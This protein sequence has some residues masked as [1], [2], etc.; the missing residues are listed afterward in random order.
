MHRDP[1][2]FDD[3]ETF[4]PERYLATKYGTKTEDDAAAFRDNMHFGSGPR[5]CPG[6]EMGS[7]IL[8]INTMNMLWAFRFSK[9]GDETSPMG[10]IDLDS[11]YQKPGMVFSPLPFKCNVVVRDGKRAR[12]IREWHAAETGEH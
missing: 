11:A 2:K 1:D 8:A 9:D 6:I 4:N 12:L 7:R 10:G 3:P 5:L